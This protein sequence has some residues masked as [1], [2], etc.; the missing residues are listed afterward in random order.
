ML[1]HWQLMT[2]KHR[3]LKLDAPKPPL[4]VVREAVEENTGEKFKFTEPL[5]AY[6]DFKPDIDPSAMDAETRGLAEVCLILF[7]SNEFAYVY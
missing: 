6:R 1:A 7:N 2:E 5:Y 4:S 3:G